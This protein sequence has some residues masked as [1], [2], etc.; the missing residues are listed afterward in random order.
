MIE[1][2]SDLYP[3]VKKLLEDMGYKVKGEV[4]SCDIAA[5][6]GDDVV[7]CELKKSFNLKLVYQL[8]DRK[9]ITPLV[10][11]VIPTPKSF[12][13]K[14]TVSMLN[15]IKKLGVGL[16][17]VSPLTMRAEIVHE[18]DDGCGR[19]TKKRVR[20]RK[21][22]VNEVDKRVSDNNGG[23]NKTELMTLYKESSLAALCYLEQNESLKT[24]YLKNEIASAV[25]SNFYGW[26]EKTG[27]AEYE[28]TELG[29]KAIL[30]KNY[31]EVIDYYRNE[32]NE[33]CLK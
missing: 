29:K 12:R 11:A 1:N 19:A 28:M 21:K 32:V 14:S 7:L 31:K 8:M 4:Q 30:N 24:R 3:S 17:T 2:E 26:F 5:V 33:K 20:I 27:R 16:I 9:N 25:K 15:L 6:K 18:P 13:A 22:I 23:V 10:Y